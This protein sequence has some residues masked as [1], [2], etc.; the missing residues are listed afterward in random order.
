MMGLLIKNIW[1]V[2]T[3]YVYACIRVETGSVS[4]TRVTYWPR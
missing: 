2:R 1:Y 3:S 4:L